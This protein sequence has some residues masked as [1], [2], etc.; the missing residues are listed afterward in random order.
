MSEMN[1]DSSKVPEWNTYYPSLSH[2]TEEQRRSYKYWRDNLERGVAIDIKGNLSYPF[3]YLYGVVDQFIKDKDIDQFLRCFE[4]IRQ[5]YSNYEKL[6]SYLSLWT[7]HAW[8]YLNNYD[9]SW[10]AAK[11]C[12]TR[13][14]LSD[15]I[16]IRANC[17]NTT[18][19]GYDL[20]RFLGNDN[21]LTPF[22][23]THLDQIASLASVFLED[24][25]K[26]HAANF[27]EF[28]SRQF[29]YSN[30]TERDLS[31]LET[32]FTNKSQ[33]KALRKKALRERPRLPQNRRQNQ[34]SELYLFWG[35]PVSQPTVEYERFPAII[36]A[37][38][39]HEGKRILRECENTLREESDLPGV[40]EGW[41]S[42]AELYHKL[43]EA[44]PDEKVVH[45]GRPAWLYP[46]HLDIYFPGQNVGC[47]YQG[48]QHQ[49]PVSYFGGEASFLKQQRRDRRKKALCTRHGCKLLYVYEGYDFETVRAATKSF[50]DA[51]MTAV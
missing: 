50:F 5:G 25:H 13:L 48:A 22:G 16:S 6:E 19:D 35:V 14:R 28:F 2:A 41:I 44:F 34:T 27:I 38:L 45:H 15:V 21:G 8:L 49:N 47:E 33:F 1:K 23:K 42:E 31:E 39:T 7:S 12:S 29:D 32:F 51:Q 11:T 40:G 4:L 37:A 9:K 36:E 24:F 30:L 3:V 18:I 26:E 43:R 20:L 46:Q 10:E 17:T